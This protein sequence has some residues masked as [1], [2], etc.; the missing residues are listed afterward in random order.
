M[1]GLRYYLDEDVD[2]GPSV[3]RE[4]RA[5]GVDTVTSVE[6]GRA[7][8]GFPDQDQLDYAT[9]QGRVF[10]TQDAHFR[11]RLPHG[12]V[13]VM[14]RRLGLGDYILYLETLAEQ[15]K[16]DDLRDQTRYCEW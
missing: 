10:V 8:K 16:S 3:A 11:P 9:R 14:Q 5:R 13:V 2:H 12:G 1:S 15:Y 4:L 6:A 7:G